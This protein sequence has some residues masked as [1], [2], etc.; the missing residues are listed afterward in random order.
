MVHEHPRFAP[1]SSLA[2]N[3]QVPPAEMSTSFTLPCLRSPVT[4]FNAILSSSDQY[5]SRNATKEES[6]EF[7]YSLL[8][9][10]G[11]RANVPDKPVESHPYQKEPSMTFEDIGD[12]NVLLKVIK[13]AFLHAVL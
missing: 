5:L 13:A 4:D 6:A 3:T 2:D 12:I 7:P 8:A 11:T 1:S 9:E 10:L